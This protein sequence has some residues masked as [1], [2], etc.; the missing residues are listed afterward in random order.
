MLFPILFFVGSAMG[1]N[2]VL[3]P[4]KVQVQRFDDVWCV[5]IDMEGSSD[6]S[7]MMPFVEPSPQSYV[8]PVQ[9]FDDVVCVSDQLRS[10]RLGTFYVK[11]C[12]RFNGTFPAVITMGTT[13]PLAHVNPMLDDHV[14]FVSGKRLTTYAMYQPNWP[15]VKA[16]PGCLAVCDATGRQVCLESVVHSSVVDRTGYHVGLSSVGLNLDYYMVCGPPQQHLLSCSEFS[17]VFGDCFENPCQIG[18]RTDKVLNRRRKAPIQ[19]IQHPLLFCLLNFKNLL[20]VDK[21][22]AALIEL[23]GFYQLHNSTASDVVVS[24]VV[25][26][27][28]GNEKLR[29]LWPL[30]FVNVITACALVSQLKWRM[31]FLQSMIYR[32]CRTEKSATEKPSV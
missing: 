13:G 9:S 26:N 19:P 31:G 16:S 28:E 18:H 25:Y 23:S 30:V 14:Y 5:A 24:T 22:T 15:N 29:S 12:Y 3:E 2:M 27:V 10:Q 8:L 6:G 1:K 7:D 20:A 4:V 32:P 17:P 21:C 11:Q